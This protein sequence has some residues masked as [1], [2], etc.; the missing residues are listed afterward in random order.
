MEKKMLTLSE[1][2]FLLTMDEKKSSVTVSSVKALPTALVSTMLIELILCNK[3]Q[4]DSNEKIIMVDSTSTDNKNLNRILN[5]IAETK[6]PKKLTFWAETFSSKP[7]NLRKELV[8]S[9]IEKKILKEKKDKLIWV[10]PFIDYSQADASAKFWRKRHLRAIVLAGE[11]IDP[12][13]AALLSLIKACGLLDHIFTNDEMKYSRRR[14]QELVRDE[15]L[16]PDFIETIDKISN[17]AALI[18]TEAESD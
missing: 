7:K 9:L 18:I 17:A 1:E 15:S 4:L 16:P 3:I 8:S 14:V 10:I 6:K 2:L 12:Q 11:K 5:N 13:S